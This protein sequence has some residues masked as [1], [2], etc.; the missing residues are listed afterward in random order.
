[1]EEK[2]EVK[3]HQEEENVRLED[4]RSESS[5]KWVEERNKDALREIF[6]AKTDSSSEEHEAFDVERTELYEE[7]LAIY[8]DKN[9]IPHVKVRGDFLYNFWQDER[10]VKGVWRRTTWTEYRKEDGVNARWE[11]LLDVDDLAK[12]ENKSWVYKGASFLCYGVGQYERADRCLISLSDGGTDSC[13]VREYD[14]S[15]KK[16]VDADDA[17]FIPDSKHSVCWKDRDTL[18]IGYTEK[19]FGFKVSSCGYPLTTKEWKRGT[20]LADAKEIYSGEESDVAAG[21]SFYYDK[22]FQ[23]AMFYRMMTFNDMEYAFMDLNSSSKEIKTLKYLPTDF[24]LQTFKNKMLLHPKTKW[25][26]AGRSYKAGSLLACDFQEFITNGEKEPT[27]I[28]IQ[29]LYEPGYRCTYEGSSD[30]RDYLYISSLENLQSKTTVYRMNDSDENF[31]LE[32]VY[33]AENCQSFSVGGAEP[34]SSNAI[35]ASS[36]GFLHPSTYLYNAKGGLVGIKTAE[37]LKS[38]TNWFDTDGMSVTLHEATS[39]DGTKVPYFL[40]RAKGNDESAG[41]RPTILNG[42]GG[43][44][45]TS[46]PSYSGGYGKAFLSKGYNFV[47][48]CIRGGGEFGPEW[49]YVAKKENRWKSFEDFNCVAEDLVKTKV[50]TAKQLGCIGGSNGGLLTGAMATHFPESFGAIV[51]QCPLLD[52]ERYILLTSGSS[53]IDEYGD[54]RD[55]TLKP[56]I[57]AWSPYHALSPD[58][59]ALMPPTLFTCST[60]DDRVHPSHARRFVEKAHRIAKDPVRAKQTILYHEMTEGGHAGAADNKNR[61]KVKTIEYTFFHEKLSRVVV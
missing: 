33:E 22:D 45:I 20:K 6:R 27:S 30:S 21:G 8:D 43:F 41:P 50:T 52:M 31:V 3:E 37:S 2:E 1:M 47:L 44:E 4:L 56:K 25:E 49:S 24:R 34:N 9:R 39:K 61:A 16:F 54:P 42:Y 46:L 11:V 59:L 60:A 38:N 57:L 58:N 14:V 48:A 12:R 40:V 5:L 26:F 51:S 18:W 53:W 35:F 32:G 7:L 13:E 19:E 55:E 28:D 15:E 36:S 29:L 17:F 23:Y 10:N